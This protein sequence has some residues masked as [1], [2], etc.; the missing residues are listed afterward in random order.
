MASLW[1]F[2]GTN[3]K[4]IGVFL[5][6]LLTL[7]WKLGYVE[8]QAALQAGTVVGMLTGARMLDRKS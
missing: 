3:R 2:W 8:A 7:L 1:K 4:A 5:I 6:S